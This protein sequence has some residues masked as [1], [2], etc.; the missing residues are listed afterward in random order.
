MIKVQSVKFLVPYKK[1]EPVLIDLKVGDI[2][3]VTITTPHSEPF[4]IDAGIDEIDLVNKQ[5]VFDTSEKFKKCLEKYCFAN[6]GNIAILN[7]EEI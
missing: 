2:V 5:I 3:K 1:G 6:I 4:T 7:Q